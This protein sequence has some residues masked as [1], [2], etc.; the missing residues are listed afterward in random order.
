M[1]RAADH[2]QVPHPFAHG[3]MRS[4]TPWDRVNL[5]LMAMAALSSRRSLPAAAFFLS[6]LPLAHTDV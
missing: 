6:L 3:G 2:D 1:A 5:Y 4:Q